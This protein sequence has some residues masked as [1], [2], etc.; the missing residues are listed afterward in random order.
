MRYRF[1]RGRYVRDSIRAPT[2]PQ[3]FCGRSPIGR[4]AGLG[5]RKLW[6]QIPPAALLQIEWWQLLARSRWSRRRIDW[7]TIQQSLAIGRLDRRLGAV[8]VIHEPMVPDP[9]E[10][11]DVTVEM[12]FGNR[13]ID[14]HQ[15]ALH[16]GK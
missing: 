14:A 6:V 12:L 4:G 8:P 13:M 7:L 1:Q 10:L 2:W 11:R 16:D 9:I 5:D 3:L 15:S